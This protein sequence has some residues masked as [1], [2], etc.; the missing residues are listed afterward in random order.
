MARAEVTLRPALRLLETSG[1]FPEWNTPSP[2]SGFILFR[3]N[4][5]S[6]RKMAKQHGGGDG[7]KVPPPN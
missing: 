7:H 6:V 4:K 1:L 2:P 3:L 5:Y